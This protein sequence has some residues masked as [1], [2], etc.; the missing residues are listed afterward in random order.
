[1]RGTRCGEGWWCL[2][3]VALLPSARLRGTDGRSWF[4]AGCK[5][6]AVPLAVAPKLHC[7]LLVSANGFGAMYGYQTVGTHRRVRR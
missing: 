2:V 7:R 1:M 3:A 5:G 4:A 6:L